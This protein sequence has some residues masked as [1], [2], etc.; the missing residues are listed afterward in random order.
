MKRGEK[1]NRLVSVRHLFRCLCFIISDR[2]NKVYHV[3]S[4]YWISKY[5]FA[6]DAE[7]CVRRLSCRSMVSCFHH[8]MLLPILFN[9]SFNLFGLKTC[10]P[11]HFDLYLS[12]RWILWL[13][14]KVA[15]PLL[16]VPFFIRKTIRTHIFSCSLAHFLWISLSNC[17]LALISIRVWF[18]VMSTIEQTIFTTERRKKI[19]FKIIECARWITVL[20]RLV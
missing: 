7:T 20:V 13:R 4:I 1:R 8:Q 10:S 19:Q 17:F 3:T 11:M 12:L 9:S 5:K 14:S 16:K 18:M 15:L 2:A 6:S